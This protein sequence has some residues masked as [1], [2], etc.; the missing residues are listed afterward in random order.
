M[1]HT[2]PYREAQEEPA[3]AWCQRCKQ[4]IYTGEQKYLWEGKWVCEDCLRAAVERMLRESPAQ[5]ALEMGLEVE[6]CL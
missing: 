5:L 3:A 4:E 1:I 2:N 6:R